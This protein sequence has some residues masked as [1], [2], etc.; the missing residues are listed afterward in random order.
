MPIP[1]PALLAALT[2]ALIA[3]AGCGGTRSPEARG[4]PELRPALAS[5]SAGP[6]DTGSDAA[7][8]A[9]RTVV[10]R[11]Y[12]ALDG[13]RR[14]MQPGPL[15]RLLTADCP[16]RAQVR[17]IRTASRRGARYTDHVHVIRLVAHLD[18]PDLVDVVVS[19]DV[20]RAGLVDAGGNRPRSTTTVRNLHRE[21][22]LRRIGDRWLIDR[23]I[24]V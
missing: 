14:R 3:G 8:A 23:V 10:R 12:T 18:R 20:S 4:L 9:A 7:L 21:L 5:R 11:Y 17:A 13:L 6:A 22:L 2:L 16:C 19:L 15:A 1:P 24:E